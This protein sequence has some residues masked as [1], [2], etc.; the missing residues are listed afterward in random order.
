MSDAAGDNR[1]FVLQALLLH[2]IVYARR[3]IGALRSIKTRHAASLKNGR[4][5]A[6][7]AGCAAWEQGECNCAFWVAQAASPGRR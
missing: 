4:N 5:D 2:T 7:S 1:R 3:A 6:A